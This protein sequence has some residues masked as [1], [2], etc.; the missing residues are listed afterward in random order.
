M[1]K[2]LCEMR[3][4]WGRKAA[5]SEGHD[6]EVALL[7]V[8]GLKQNR[9]DHKRGTVF[10]PD[11]DWEYAQLEMPRFE[12]TN[13]TKRA[14]LHPRVAQVRAEVEEATTEINEFIYQISQEEKRA[15]DDAREILVGIVKQFGERAKVFTPGFCYT[16]R[17]K[18][19]AP[20]GKAA[21]KRKTAE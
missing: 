7:V 5:R 21:K 11:V 1:A 9:P 20:K 14:C 8:E 3:S 18:R 12:P 4:D 13:F 16:V 6:R 10:L 19:K 2:E 15:H 17:S